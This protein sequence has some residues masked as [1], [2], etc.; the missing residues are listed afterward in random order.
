M[1][2]K[3]PILS[4]SCSAKRCVL[5]IVLAEHEHDKIRQKE[6]SGEKLFRD[7]DD[8]RAADF[9]VP[10]AVGIGSAPNR[11]LLR[12]VARAGLGTEHIVSDDAGADAAAGRLL[13]AT[14]RPV[15]TDI[16]V[17]GSGVVRIAPE[18]PSDV[19]A[20]RPLSLTA[21]LSPEGGTLELSG[22]LAGS[23]SP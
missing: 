12:G 7:V 9:S 6:P 21:E 15:L 4:C 19:A 20:G 23:T 22:R 18:R 8:E 14:D 1:P 11:T 16:T 17:T 3:C 2:R 5:V 13:A 10:H